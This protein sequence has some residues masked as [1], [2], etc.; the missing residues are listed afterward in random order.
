MKA[1]P[2]QQIRKS[3]TM[4][5]MERKTFSEF[6]ALNNL[7]NNLLYYCTRALNHPV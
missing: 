6:S 1:T 4:A 5:N 3:A 2:T 7:P